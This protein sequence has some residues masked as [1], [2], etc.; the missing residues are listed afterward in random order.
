MCYICYNRHFCAIYSCAISWWLE[1]SQKSYT[2]HYNIKL[3][4]LFYLILLWSWNEGFFW[5]AMLSVPVHN[6][7]SDEC[8]GCPKHSITLQWETE[9]MDE[10]MV[11]NPVDVKKKR[12]SNLFTHNDCSLFFA[13]KWKY[14]AYKHS[15]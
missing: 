11:H 1:N 13:A 14:Q 6:G 10:F 8:N 7:N 5:L 15:H 9:T 2:W 4:H 3:Y 12:I